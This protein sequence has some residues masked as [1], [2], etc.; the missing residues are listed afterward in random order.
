MLCAAEPNR[1]TACLSASDQLESAGGG[2]R[3]RSLGSCAVALSV[4]H[5]QEMLTPPRETKRR[6]PLPGPAC[7]FAHARSCRCSVSTSAKSKYSP[8]VRAAPPAS[9]YHH[10]HQ[11]IN[12]HHHQS[13]IINHQSSSII[14]VLLKCPSHVRWRMVRCDGC[15]TRL[16]CWRLVCVVAGGAAALTH[17]RIAVELEA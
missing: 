16:C 1:M 3:R 12:H 11:S 17:D 2:G 6:L 13:S 14:G 5:A 9:S 10:H 7:F 15:G 8:P 4:H